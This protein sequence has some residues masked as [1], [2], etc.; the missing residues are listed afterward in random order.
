MKPQDVIDELRATDRGRQTLAAL[1][2]LAALWPELDSSHRAR[3]RD[4]IYGLETHTGTIADACSA[5]AQAAQAAADLARGR[6]LLD[7]M[8]DSRE[9]D[10]YQGDRLGNDLFINDPD[11]A[12]RIRK[13]AGHGADGSTHAERLEDMRDFLRDVWKEEL[14]EDDDLADERADLIE[15]AIDACE[16]WH[17]ANGTLNKEIG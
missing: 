17:E 12:D 4:V 15:S 6:A 3:M 5:A 13:A 9:W 8:L 7:E 14:S 10:S 16:A 11:R 2:P 1:A